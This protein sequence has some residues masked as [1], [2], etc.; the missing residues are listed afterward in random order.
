MK[1][2]SF[3]WIFNS[4]GSEE[5]YKAYLIAKDSTEK[6]GI[7]YK[8][9]LTL[10][11]MKDSFRTTI[12]LIAHYNVELHHMDVKV[13]FLNGDIGKTIVWCN[14]KNCVGDQKK[15]VCKLTKSMYGLRK[16]FRWWPYKFHQV[17]LSFCFEMNVGDD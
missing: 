7:D 6:Q 13:M 1:P 4:K 3:K 5:M 2:V 8:D 10:V 12:A 11:S 15:M 14:K 17:I 9:T 16:A